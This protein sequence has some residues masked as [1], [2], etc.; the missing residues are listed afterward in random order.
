MDR[1]LIVTDQGVRAE[2]LLV[3]VKR[4]LTEAH[5]QFDV[6]DISAGE[7]TVQSV[8]ALSDAY[9]QSDATGMIAVGGGSVIDSCKAAGVLATHPGP[10]ERYQ[11][12]GEAITR[13]IPF[14]I[15]IPTTAGTGSEISTGSVLLDRDCRVKLVLASPLISPW[16][17][18]DDP[19]MTR[20]LP[21]QMTAISGMDA[22]AH[23]I[24]RFT[25][26]R[27]APHT[28]APAIRGV[29]LV[30]ANLRRAVFD[31]GDMEAR[32]GMLAG[33]LLGGMSRTGLSVAH[34]IG[35][36][37]G[38]WYHVPHGLACAIPLPHVMKYNATAVQGRFVEV[39]EALGERM[40][41]R[42]PVAAALRAGD[43][44]A[45]LME[46]I[47]LPTR[48]AEVGVPDDDLDKLAEATLRDNYFVLPSN[49]RRVSLEDLKT[50]YRGML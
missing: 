44:V 43:A 32:Y 31:G 24:E 42:S 18:L 21:P 11:L 3:P 13:R 8:E 35:A 17:A 49:P 27:S 28:D 40:V 22:L 25:S 7:P 4:S 14:L 48:L 46:D 45:E 36:T 23:C 1:P 26:A 39:A 34:A 15:A 2:G 37:V 5:L 30:G 47:G 19:E 12:D 29:R 9:R 38:A 20:S 6:Y 41:C 33:S 50:L 16:V 10:P